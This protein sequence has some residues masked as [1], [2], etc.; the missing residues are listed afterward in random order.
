MDT[1]G[2]YGFD[3]SGVFGIE[4]VN[5]QAVL[6]E[7]PDI[8]FGDTSVKTDTETLYTSQSTDADSQEIYYLW[9]WSD[10]NSSAWLDLFASGE[11]VSPTYQWDENG[12]YQIRVM[13]KDEAGL[14]SDWSDPLTVGI[15]KNAPTLKTALIQLLE[16]LMNMCPVLS[17]MIQLL[18]FFL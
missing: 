6:P 17:S 16:N 9:Y 14:V 15:T 2:L 5:A 3:I 4:K 1:D 18:L 13:V 8:P 10:S 12:N 11:I 7:T